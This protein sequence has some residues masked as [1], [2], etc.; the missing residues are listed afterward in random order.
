[1]VFWPAGRPG[2][3]FRI[4]GCQISSHPL[5]TATQKHFFGTK[6]AFWRSGKDYFLLIRFIQ[7]VFSV[8]SH[9][10]HFSKP[11]YHLKTITPFLKPLFHHSGNHDTTFLKTIIP[12][13]KPWYHFWKPLHHFWNHYTTFFK[14]IIPFLKPWYH[15]LKT[16]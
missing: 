11:W 14:T 1:M 15:F 12:F 7:I 10:H 3:F 8:K 2:D 13:S 9:S 16:L 4:S 5:K 6:N